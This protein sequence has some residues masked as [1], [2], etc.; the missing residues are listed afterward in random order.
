MH[1]G[2][3]RQFNKRVHVCPPFFTEVSNQGCCTL[4]I[5]SHWP[6]A[7]SQVLQLFGW[8][9]YAFLKPPLHH[10]QHCVVEKSGVL[11]DEG[12]LLWVLLASEAV[13]HMLYGH[14]DDLPEAFQQ[15]HV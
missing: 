6:G 4:W 10:R 7:L 14:Q 9:A 1:G 11:H 8:L 13:V 2:I 3:K 15:H 5:N 12:L